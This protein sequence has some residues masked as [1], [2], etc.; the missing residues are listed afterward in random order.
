MVLRRGDIAPA[1]RGLWDVYLNS[2]VAVRSQVAKTQ[3]MLGILA[4]RDKADRKNFI[5]AKAAKRDIDQLG[6]D[7][8]PPSSNDP[9]PV[10]LAVAEDGQYSRL[11]S[12]TTSRPRREEGVHVVDVEINLNP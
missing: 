8:T 3:S 9:L 5:A 1:S 4:K 2:V 10:W 6:A 11:Y 7:G 12:R